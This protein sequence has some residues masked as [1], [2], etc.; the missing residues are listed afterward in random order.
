[1]IWPE[2]G[3]ENTKFFQVYSKSRKMVN[4]IWSL[5]DAE[6][7]KVSSFEGMARL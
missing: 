4:I 1:V 5:I 6:G 2:K 7:R 3:D